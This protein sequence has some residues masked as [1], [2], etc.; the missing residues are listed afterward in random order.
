MSQ[1]DDYDTGGLTRVRLRDCVPFACGGKRACYVHPDHPDRC[2]KLPLP[3]QM[4]VDI[5]RRAPWHRR[6]RKS[7]LDFDEN[8]REWLASH[9][10]ACQGDDSVWQHVPRCHGWVNSDL[11]CGLV[12][13]LCREPD[14]CISPNLLNYLNTHGGTHAVRA[15]VAH[16]ADFWVGHRIPAHDFMISNLVCQT[17]SEG[18]LHIWMIDGLGCRTFIPFTQWFVFAGRR[19]ARR[20][21]QCFYQRFELTLDR[22]DQ[23]THSNTSLHHPIPPASALGHYKGNSDGGL[24]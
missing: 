17:L 12:V 11:G 22:L 18:A 4:P 20:R 23:T 15:A 6:M 16:F 3:D 19:D 24:R 10:L 5:Y 2:I 21:I 8:H 13:D 9:W 14:G 1:H 7:I